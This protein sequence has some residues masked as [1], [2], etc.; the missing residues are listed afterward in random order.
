MQIF[1]GVDYP[2]AKT[3]ER[4]GPRNKIGVRLFTDKSLLEGPRKVGKIQF[5]GLRVYEIEQ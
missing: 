3:R 2:F 1:K 4:E 5:W